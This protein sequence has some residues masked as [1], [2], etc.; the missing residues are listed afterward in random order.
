MS[1]YVRSRLKIELYEPSAA[2]SYTLSVLSF[3]ISSQNYLPLLEYTMLTYM[4]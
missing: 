1:A 4:K 3:A 2:H